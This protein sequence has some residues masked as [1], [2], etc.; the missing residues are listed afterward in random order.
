[1]KE[2]SASLAVPASSAEGVAWPAVPHPAGATMLALQFQLGRSQW[3]TPDALRAQ[4]FRQLRLLVEHAILNVPHYRHHLERAGLRS[5]AELDEA[6]YR[7]WPLL[8]SRDITT[9]AERLMAARYPKEHGGTFDSFTSGATGTPKKIRQTEAAQLFVHALVLRDHLWHARDFTAKFGAIRFFATEG[10]SPTWSRVTSAV[11]ETG[12][13]AEIDV[14]TDVPLQLDWLLREKPAYLLTSPS[15]L[16]ALLAESERTGRVPDGLRQ[17]ITYAESLPGT[18]RRDLARLWGAPLV[19]SY[20]STEAGAI[21]L[22]C[23]ASTDGRY[24]VQSEN[25]LVEVLGDDGRPCAPGETGRVVITPL[26]NFAMPLLRYELG[27]YAVAGEACACGRGLPV[28]R[29]VLGRVRNMACDPHGRRF[30]PGFDQALED[31]RLPV[32]QFQ[33]IQETPS[34]IEMRY[35]MARELTRD[36][37]SR[38]SQAV[39]QRLPYPFEMRYRRV[40]AIERSPG[41]KYEGF[42]SLVGTELEGQGKR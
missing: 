10:R 25:V 28:I 34:L 18:L 41:G 40:E 42:I 33:F 1:M 14:T 20:S 39:E 4:Q 29:K 5:V 27:D 26:H 38:F 21:A 17:V 6:A 11:F 3:W 24:H 37:Q 16:R 22:Q 2:A 35:V 8:R 13:G 30:Q 15:N 7:R 19:D 23:P 31:T 36:E 12:A 32:E 9:N